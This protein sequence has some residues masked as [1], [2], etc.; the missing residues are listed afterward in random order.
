[1]KNK[2]LLLLS[3][4]IGH[5]FILEKM[6]KIIILSLT[7]L[8]VLSCTTNKKCDNN[9]INPP[10]CTICQK[11]RILLGN[12]CITNVQKIPKI[13]DLKNEFKGNN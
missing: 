8:F 3:I 11:D 4:L 7:I 2:E 1:M 5:L 10:K 12:K 13:M 6:L 9:A